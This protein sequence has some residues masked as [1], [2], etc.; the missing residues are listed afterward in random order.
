MLRWL[1]IVLGLN[2]TVL[3]V[4]DSKGRELEYDEILT[5][6][7]VKKM[8]KELGLNFMDIADT[9]I[10]VGID[11]NGNNYYVEPPQEKN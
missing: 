7:D 10:L 9:L 5:S 3:K 6:S 8:A 4:I 2:N 11:D 1:I